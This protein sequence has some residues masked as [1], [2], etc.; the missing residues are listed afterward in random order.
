MRYLYVVYAILLFVLFFLIVLPFIVLFSLFGAWGRKTNWRIVQAWAYVWFFLVGLRNKNIYEAKPE[1]RKTYI[2][3]ANHCSFLDTPTIFRAIP[4][5]VKPLAT[6]EYS[7][8]P[9]F[10]FLYKQLT[11]MIDRSSQKSKAEGARMLKQTLEEGSSIFIFPEGKFNETEHSLL[12]FYDGAFK[13]AMQ[14]NTPILP[15]L[16]LDT[17]IRMS[18]K[19]I[20]RF[21]PGRNRVVFLPEVAPELFKGDVQAFKQQVYDKMKIAFDTYKN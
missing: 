15:L 4:F 8:I 11:V 3:V 20:W 18:Y 16:F 6:F 14:T 5:F 17:D 21:N 19:S 7:R 12:A 2:V 13:I 10:G 9:V 1:K